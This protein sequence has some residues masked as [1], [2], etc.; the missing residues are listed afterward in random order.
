MTVIS[1][2]ISDK[3]SDNLKEP[4]VENIVVDDSNE[5]KFKLRTIMLS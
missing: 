2:N 3:K 5:V 4:L 1:K